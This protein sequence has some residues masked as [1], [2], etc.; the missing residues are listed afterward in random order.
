MS[1]SLYESRRFGRLEDLKGT[2]FRSYMRVHDDVHRTEGSEDD[3]TVL[4]RS[5][6][7]GPVF[8]GTNDIKGLSL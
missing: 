1:P 3:T 8:L 5:C 6:L 4:R 2:L 7:P